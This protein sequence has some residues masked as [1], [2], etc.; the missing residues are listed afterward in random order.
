M[1]KI[2]LIFPN[3]KLGAGGRGERW[4][5]VFCDGACSWKINARMD[6]RARNFYQGDIWSAMRVQEGHQL[7]RFA[8]TLAAVCKFYTLTNWT[9]L[10]PLV[11][12]LKRCIGCK[13][14]IRIRVKQW[15]LPFLLILMLRWIAFIVC[16]RWLGWAT[17][18]NGS[19]FSLCILLSLDPFCFRKWFRDCIPTSLSCISI[20][21]I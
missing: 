9:H 3:H 17:Q 7:L 19:F 6:N 18:Y 13:A 12:G 10:S 4:N 8:D 11:D 1:A 15:E 2:V 20:I 14:F 21:F 5:C 16:S